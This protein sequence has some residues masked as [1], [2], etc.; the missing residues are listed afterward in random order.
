MLDADEQGFH[1][2][3]S[4][5]APSWGRCRQRWPRRR[6]GS[7]RQPKGEI[8]VNWFRNLKVVTKLTLGFGL[9]AVLVVVVGMQG[10]R[11]MAQTDERLKAI[12]EQHALGVVKLLEADVHMLHMSRTVRNMV[13]DVGTERLANRTEEI[14]DEPEAVRE[15]IRGIPADDPRRGF[16][17]AAQ[18][19]G[20]GEAP[21]SSS[22][23]SSRTSCS[24][25]RAGGCPGCSPRARISTSMRG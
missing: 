13:L 8:T 11:G 15:G 19:R 17:P 20:G 18:G 6:V 14:E 24:S 1:E 10:L 3:S 22:A 7:A 21:G 25:P 12:H 16:G 9:L 5:K 23:T 4:G 2:G